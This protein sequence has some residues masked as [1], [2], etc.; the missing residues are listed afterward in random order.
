MRIFPILV[1]VLCLSQIMYGQTKVSLKD[2]VA[3]TQDNYFV[4]EI[5]FLNTNKNIWDDTVKYNQKYSYKLINFNRLVFK[6]YTAEQKGENFNTERPAALKGLAFP[7][8]LSVK[9]VQPGPA[10]RGEV[11][12]SEIKKILAAI[13]ACHCVDVVTYLLTIKDMNQQI[14]LVKGTGESLEKLSAKFETY[15]EL[16]Q[17]LDKLK[18]NTVNSFGHIDSSKRSLIKKFTGVETGP[19][20]TS[21]V[22][23]VFYQQTYESAQKLINDRFFTATS[24]L[25]R[26][27]DLL[28]SKYQVCVTDLEKK[29]CGRKDTCSKSYDSILLQ[30]KEKKLCIRKIQSFILGIKDDITEA[31]AALKTMKAALKEQRIYAVQ[32]NYNM[33]ERRNFELYIEPFVADKDKHVITFTA[34]ADGPLEYGVPSQRTIKVNAVTYGGFKI[35]FSTGAFFNWG[36]NNF[37]GPKYY[38]EL[39]T[40]S[41]K[42]IREAGRTKSGLLSIGALMHVSYRTNS[43]LRPALSF[44]ISTT[45]GFNALNFHG[46]ISLIFGKPGR[47]NRV[48]LSSGI[49]LREVDLLSSGYSVNA[50]GKNF[51]VVIPVS[52]NFPVMGYFVALTYNLTGVNK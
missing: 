34:K 8:F 9:G 36:S 33:L 5:D 32:Q 20:D 26:E 13:E 42:I 28:A 23:A 51:P 15:P 44:G 52:K 12:S 31:D 50:E 25:I 22:I 11:D 29:L 40:D 1:S 37:L 41:T 16:N 14:V 48:I 21:Q 19:N 24:S 45:S 39:P 17:E 30:I 35:D 7:G 47:A 49:T 10:S 46:G 6:Q 27:S 4:K 2:D 38:Y 43:F 18:K 3:K